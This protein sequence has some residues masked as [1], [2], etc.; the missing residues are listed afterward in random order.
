MRHVP[1]LI[2]R[3]VVASFKPWEGDRGTPWCGRVEE[4]YTFL[5]NLGFIHGT[6]WPIVSLC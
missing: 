5:E 1:L 6:C 2:R 4:F 3:G